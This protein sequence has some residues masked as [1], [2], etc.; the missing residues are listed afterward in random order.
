MC[1]VGG[2]VA[3]ALSGTALAETD[4][5]IETVAAQIR[6]LQ[7]ALD[8][9]VERLDQQ[10]AALDVQ[11]QSIRTQ[12]QELERLTRSLAPDSGAV[13]HPEIRVGAAPTAPEAVDLV[14]LPQRTGVLTPARSWSAD[15][16]VQFSHS[17][18]QRVSLLG[19]SIVPAIVVG[20]I[21]LREL[22]SRTTAAALAIRYGLTDRMELE[23]RAP[24]LWRDEAVRSRPLSQGADADALFERNGA[25]FGDVELTLRRQ[26]N[27][28]G[29]GA[30]LMI[31]SLR[32]RAPTGSDAFGIP[33]DSVSGMG[34]A[35][36]TGSGFWGVESSVTTL[37]RSDPAAFFSSLSYLWNI[38]RNQGR[39]FGRIDPGDVIG[40][41]F[42][43]G[44]AI[45]DR[46][47]FTAGY[48]HRVVMPTDVDRGS[49]A[50]HRQTHLGSLLLGYS[51]A[52]DSGR[53]MQLTLSAGLT[54]DAP[55]V[56]IGVRTALPGLR[57]R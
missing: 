23:L 53:T 17:S 16:T 27:T 34:T 13:E 47:S 37:I 43:M 52:F 39:D 38:D 31:G 15:S 3:A 8:A 40:L 36:P 26:L 54:E 12:R 5:A 21:D 55:D 46:L 4:P 7:A 9:Q 24:Y 56:Q 48:E 14:S 2:A 57:T 49:T 42:G 20:A 29:D 10:Q 25:G 6:A 35:L 18:S 51:L 19:Y 11:K 22:D 50:L 41:D 33:R 28:P 30:P 45:N 44:F 32:V 1:C